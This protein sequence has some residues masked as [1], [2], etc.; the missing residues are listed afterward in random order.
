M[1]H[2][3]ILLLALPMVLAGCGGS[4]KNAE[5][6]TSKKSKH[7][8]VEDSLKNLD[9][10]TLIGGIYLG[11]DSVEYSEKIKA[12]DSLLSKNGI[13]IANF[14]F[15]KTGASFHNNKLYSFRLLSEKE[16]NGNMDALAIHITNARREFDIVNEFLSDKYGQS[17]SYVSDLSKDARQYGIASWDFNFF[18]VEYNQATVTRLSKVVYDN[19]DVT[20]RGD[21]E[22]SCPKEYTDEEI[23]ASKKEVEE[24][25]RERDRKQHL[26]DSL[27]NLL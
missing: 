13:K 10:I 17:Q 26:N 22:Y 2:L 21:I 11:M 5:A 16:Y 6:E 19:G 3:L 9:K 7:E 14:T 8:I 25:E 15:N 1:K 20:I 23:A 12:V 4:V 18:K 24:Y 27:R